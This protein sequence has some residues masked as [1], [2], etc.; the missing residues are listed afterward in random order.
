[1]NK[2]VFIGFIVVLCIAIFTGCIKSGNGILLVKAKDFN[3]SYQ[4]EN[5]IED[6]ERYSKAYKIFQNLD[7]KNAKL[8]VTKKPDYI[9]EF[10][11]D[12]PSSDDSKIANKD[13]EIW[14][15]RDK[16]TATIYIDKDSKKGTLFEK[17]MKEL[18]FLW[19]KKK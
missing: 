1:M 19:E 3:G 18:E 9:L 10:K 14:L 16:K 4:N 7:W 5:K 11:I 6:K 2:N 17:E 13:I 15:D 12:N 8:D